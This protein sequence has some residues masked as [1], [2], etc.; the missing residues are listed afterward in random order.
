[1]ASYTARKTHPPI[2]RKLARK[3]NP[4]GAVAQLARKLAV[5]EPLPKGYLDQI[6]LKLEKDTP[7]WSAAPEDLWGS[8]EGYYE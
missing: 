7:V 4:Y 6:D 3:A 1:M 5:Q 8:P 2:F